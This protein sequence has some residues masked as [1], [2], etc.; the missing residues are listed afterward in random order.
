MN[1]DRPQDGW[2]VICPSKSGRGED[3]VA[4]YLSEQDA[5]S[6][7]ASSDPEPHGAT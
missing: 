2:K 1:P 6:I 5:R 7:A 4:S 3:L